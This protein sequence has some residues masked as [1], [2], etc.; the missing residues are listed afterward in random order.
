MGRKR[1]GGDDLT[2]E[3]R[4]TLLSGQLEA[5]N[6]RIAILE[7]HAGM[8][9]T[10][11]PDPPPLPAKEAA[12]PYALGE[13]EDISEEVIGWA[14][15]TSLFPRLATLCFLLVLALILRTITDSGM[16]NTLL[17]SAL[18]MGYA[19][20]L[21]A[22]SWYQ[23]RRESPLAPVFAACGALLL[24]IIVVETHTRF[25]AL[26]LVPAYFTLMATGTIMAVLSRQFGVFLPVSVGTLGMC[27][28]GAAIDYPDPFFPYLSMI[29]LTANLLGYY[30][31]TL[32][33]CSWL[34][35]IVLIV[36]LF[37][38]QLWGMRLGLAHAR[39]LPTSAA[40]AADWF[41]PVLATFSVAY[42]GIA[43][44]GIVR[45][46][47]D[48]V[49]RFDYTLPTVTV[50][51]FYLMAK[52]VVLASSGNIQ[53]LSF[54]ALFFAL[55]HVGAGFWLAGR[56][57][58]GAPGTNSLLFAGGILLALS[59][60]DACGSLLI[61]TPPLAASAFA[62][63][64]LSRQWESGGIRL[65][66]YLLQGY[67][68]VALFLFFT[69]AGTRTVT[70]TAPVVAAMLSLIGLCHY[71]WCRNQ[72][73]PARSVIF[74]RYDRHDLGA[75][76]LF[77]GSLTSAF[78]ALRSI[79]HHLLPQFNAD[80]ANAYPCS[81]SLIINLAAIGLALYAFRARNREIRNV[82][83]LVTVVGAGKV[84]LYDLI[85]TK[86]VPLVLSVFSFGLAAALLSIVLG[87]WQGTNV[88]SGV[89]RQQ[90]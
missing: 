82:A 37:M 89:P 41:Y 22:A 50:V 64:L 78:F 45:S 35:W 70:V 51:W 65:T 66:S 40:L 80:L 63:A 32:K 19:A 87:R 14:G 27:L 25:K 81:Q 29:L 43:L 42:L 5:M 55:L 2:L 49:S 10:T 33:R 13:P 11:A 44:M 47:S 48:K 26:P 31:A 28:A 54:I 88:S 36:T 52:T 59:L 7:R 24:S 6:H 46:G 62:L 72:Q 67:N 20:A 60:P 61:A 79:V 85:G 71:R 12:D 86:G 8:T 15:K 90:S 4:L 9:V 69:A 16:I 83:I 39:H 56:H 58:D 73:P 17:G 75:A 23:Y 57:V 68:A 3:Q 76:T 1:M 38:L 74:D 77:L 30:A 21:I 53:H 34:R 18:G 84:F